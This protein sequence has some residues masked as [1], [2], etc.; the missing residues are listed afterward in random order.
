MVHRWVSPVERYK[1]YTSE[2][3]VLALEKLYFFSTRFYSSRGFLRAVALHTIQ[4]HLVDS[5]FGVFFFVSRTFNKSGSALK[6]SKRW[7]TSQMWSA[8]RLSVSANNQKVDL[9]SVWGNRINFSSGNYL[10]FTR[11]PSALS[12]MIDVIKSLYL[13]I[14]N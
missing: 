4:M 2:W 12:L 14:C 5:F 7:I 10:F 8:V 6:F 3:H 11:S 13:M 1:V 9:K